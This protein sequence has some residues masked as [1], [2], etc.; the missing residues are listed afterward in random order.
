MANSAGIIYTP[1]AC[2]EL[3]SYFLSA[4]IEQL[5]TGENI[6]LTFL[7]IPKPTYAH[8]HTSMQNTNCSYN[9]SKISCDF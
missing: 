9:I 1:S 8:M 7:N 2:A 4:Y 5:G 3:Y 6:D